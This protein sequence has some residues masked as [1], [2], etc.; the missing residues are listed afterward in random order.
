DLQ[1][2]EIKQETD[3]TPKIDSGNCDD[4]TNSTSSN[5]WQIEDAANDDE[6][7]C[8]T[9]YRELSQSMKILE[10]KFVNDLRLVI[11]QEQAD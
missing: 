11:N 8:E 10:R 6:Y 5:S 7:D 1:T 2:G 9:Q 4:E 3:I